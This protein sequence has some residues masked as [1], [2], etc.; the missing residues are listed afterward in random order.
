MTY[1]DKYYKIF[2][3]TILIASIIVATLLL[4]YYY[5]SPNFLSFLRKHSL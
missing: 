4:L 2:I 1:N 5:T 3:V